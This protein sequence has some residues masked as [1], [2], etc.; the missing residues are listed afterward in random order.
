MKKHFNYNINLQI[1]LISPHLASK[2]LPMSLHC[3]QSQPVRE[4]NVVKDQ[5]WVIKALCCFPAWSPECEWVFVFTKYTLSLSPSLTSLIAVEDLGKLFP[6]VRL[7]YL[8]SSADS[9]SFSWN[10]KIQIHHI[11]VSSV[12]LLTQ[13]LHYCYRQATWWIVVAANR[14]LLLQLDCLDVQY[15]HIYKYC[16][17]YH[18]EYTSPFMLETVFSH[19]C[20]LFCYCASVCPGGGIPHLWLS[21]GFC[22]FCPLLK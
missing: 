5:L 21:E 16:C 2:G 9:L 8:F 20:L 10:V 18:Y 19:E 13:L 14:R 15:A 6:P 17:Q 3:N 12:H 11:I 7:W 4:V 22:V 1:R